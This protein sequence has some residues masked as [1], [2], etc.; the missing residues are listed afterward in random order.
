LFFQKARGACVISLVC[1]SVACGSTGDA[2]TESQ[3]TARGDAAFPVTVRAT[4]GS[5]SIP[6]RPERI[7][8]IS[9]TATE[10]L[11]AIGAGPQVVAVDD[12]SN[13]PTSAPTTKLSSFQPNVE[14]I[15]GY[16]PD[17][18]IAAS[19]TGGL[20]KGLE[21]L[22]IP[23]LIQPAAGALSDSY[24][25][26]EQLGTATGHEEQAASTVS[27][28]RSDTRGIIDATPRAAPA[29]SV[30]HELDDTYY[31]ATS[32]TFIGKVYRAFGLRNIA[33]AARGGAGD[34]PQLSAEFV[35]SADPDLIFLADT[36]C[37]GQSAATVRDRPGWQDIT[38]VRDHDV[39]P[40]DDDI[41][42]RWGPRIVE[43]YRLVSDEVTAVERHAGAA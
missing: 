41:A 21:S 1:V 11:F 26:L 28:M 27:A 15:A 40:V 8:S 2:P 29:L 33:D 6:S 20:L 32:T 17:L 43:F 10:M 31:S 22:H 18:V 19:D 35:V 34:Y 7:V 37:C 36:K 14:A 25:Q 9:P 4:N 39:V 42:S 24:E 23:V 38:A 3:P 13:F 5:V 16:G 30:Y 12:Q